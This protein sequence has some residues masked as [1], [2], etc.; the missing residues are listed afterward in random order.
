MGQGITHITSKTV[1]PSLKGLSSLASDIN[2][3]QLLEDSSLTA[4]FNFNEKLA[5]EAIATYNNDSQAINELL[6]QYQKNLHPEIKKLGNCPY[7]DV[8]SMSNIA[9]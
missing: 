7:F 6:T 2:F 1:T 5:T 3:T 4:C 9:T 8:S